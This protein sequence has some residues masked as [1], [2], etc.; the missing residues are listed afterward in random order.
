MSVV[1]EVV[2]KRKKGRRQGLTRVDRCQKPRGGRHDPCT[3]LPHHPNNHYIEA[4]QSKHFSYKPL[5]LLSCPSITETKYIITFPQANIIVSS[6]NLSISLSPKKKIACDKIL[7]SQKEGFGKID[8][9]SLSKSRLIKLGRGET[10]PHD[11]E[12]RPRRFKAWTWIDLLLLGHKWMLPISFLSTQP[13]QPAL[14]SKLVHFCRPQLAL[15]VSRRPAFP[16][17]IRS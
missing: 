10:R 6:I 3:R 2:L 9:W 11:Q 8:S 12:R 7:S 17:V 1:D 16:S 4:H 5:N 15:F 14:Q 13:Q